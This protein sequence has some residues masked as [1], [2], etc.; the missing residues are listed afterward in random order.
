MKTIK[1]KLKKAEDGTEVNEGKTKT[2]VS[3]GFNA[4]FSNPE[5]RSGISRVT[6][7]T[8]KMDD[9]GNRY[10]V[11]LTESNL[12]PDLTRKE[13]TRVTSKV[14]ERTGPLGLGVKKTVTKYDAQGNTLSSQ[15]TERKGLFGKKVTTDLTESRRGGSTKAKMKKTS[16]KK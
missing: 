5:N 7:T 11:K 6:K 15:A 10:K 1:K 8:G 3:R 4:P 14:K 9:T 16:K 13:N 12:S 2:R